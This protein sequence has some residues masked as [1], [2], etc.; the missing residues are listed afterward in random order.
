MMRYSILTAFALLFAYSAQAGVKPEAY[1][2]IKIK[3][4]F[5]GLIIRDKDD[6]VYSGQIK[7]E[8]GLVE[9]PGYLFPNLSILF[10]LEYC[11]VGDQA[12]FRFA[13]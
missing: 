2:K 3:P 4:V 1:L 8:A 12:T 13:L 11:D 5:S 10:G 9:F 6:F 7:S